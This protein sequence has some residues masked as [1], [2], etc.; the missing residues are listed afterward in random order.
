MYSFNDYRI[1]NYVQNVIFHIN[2]NYSFSKNF[3]F[4]ELSIFSKHTY[5]LQFQMSLIYKIHT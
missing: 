1:R 5:Y 2:E 4:N 3:V